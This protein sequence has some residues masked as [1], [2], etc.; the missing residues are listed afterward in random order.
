MSDGIGKQVG[1]RLDGEFTSGITADN[2][3]YD[4]NFICICQTRS[5]LVLR[6]SHIDDDLLN[7][8]FIDCLWLI[9]LGKVNATLISSYTNLILGNPYN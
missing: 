5:N 3:L 7:E 1:I 4:F 6:K 2:L 9:L 8:A